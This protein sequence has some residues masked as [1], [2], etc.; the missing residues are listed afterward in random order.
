MKYEALSRD[1]SV[2]SVVG[3]MSGTSLDGLDLVHAQFVNSD[4]K[5]RYSILATKY[6]AYDESLVDKLKEAIHYSARE[7]LLF[8]IEYGKW[9]GLR[10]KEFLE[11][12]RAAV[13]FIACHGHTIFHQPQKGLTFQLGD[14]QMLSGLCQ[15]PV[16]NDFR[17]LDIALGGQG[18]PLV[19]V[20]DQLLFEK[21]HYCLNL[22]GI[23]NISYTFKDHQIAYD[24]T[25]VNILLN[26]LVNKIGQS[27]DREGLHARSGKLIKS[28]LD[29]LNDINYY[30]QSI[31]KSLGYEWFME[32]VV[33]ILEAAEGSVQD[34][35]HTACHH[36][37]FQ[38]S[39]QISPA[40][41]GT[42]KMLCTGGGAK[43]QFLIEMIRHYL[44][45][46]VEITIPGKDLTDFKEALIFAFLGVLR[47]RGEVNCLA[48]VTGAKVS[49]CAG[50]IYHPE[51]YE[52]I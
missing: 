1:K 41:S 6:I 49:S 23:A 48:S 16:I 18:A 32:V 15:K 45:E 24:I 43:N 34:K 10:T 25:V 20:G 9:L 36:I 51:G 47:V 40:K 7:L 17:S 12:E 27:Y 3:L 31:P 28:L 50:H 8:H 22:G 42:S 39:S 2:F 38:I 26:Y 37:A 29:S 30:R 14:G 33:P 13:D 5:W 4:N 11:E 46:R 52:S 44:N 35:L 19:P 21:Y